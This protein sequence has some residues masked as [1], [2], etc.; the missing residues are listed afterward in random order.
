MYCA[1]SQAKHDSAL[2]TSLYPPPAASSTSPMFLS[3]CSACVM[4]TENYIDVCTHYI[5]L[6]LGQRAPAYNVP[7]LANP[8]LARDV[9]GAINHHRLEGEDV[10]S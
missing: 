7:V 8:Q 10:W 9:E 1:R 5:A 6:Y 4:C 2:M 3:A